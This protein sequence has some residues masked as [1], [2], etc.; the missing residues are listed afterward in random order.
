[1]LGWRQEEL[2]GE[3]SGKMSSFQIMLVLKGSV[4]HGRLLTSEQKRS[5]QRNINHLAVFSGRV[6]VFL[7]ETDD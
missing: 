5:N 3:P 2:E 4:E 1:M 7:Q 6:T